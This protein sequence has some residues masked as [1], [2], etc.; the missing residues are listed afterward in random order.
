MINIALY[1]NNR[2]KLKIVKTIQNREIQ[3]NGI[4]VSKTRNVIL[5]FIFDVSEKHSNKI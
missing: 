5:I 2:S 1:S 4:E 3:I